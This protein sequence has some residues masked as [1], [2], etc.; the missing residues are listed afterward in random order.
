MPVKLERS[1]RADSP[2]GSYWLGHCTGFQ[3]KGFRRSGTVEEVELAVDGRV[4]ALAVRRHGFFRNRL[5]LVPAY[6]VATVDPWDEMVVLARGRS[7]G[8]ARTY[9]PPARAAVA[10][11]S[12]A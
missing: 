3:V 9:V 12:L 11:G 10:A 4:D 7:N 2:I 6:A 5:I 1:F 8:R